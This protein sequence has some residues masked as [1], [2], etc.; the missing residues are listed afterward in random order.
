MV[1]KNL[2]LPLNLALPR[3]ENHPMLVACGIY[4]PAAI[5]QLEFL[6][7]QENFSFSDRIQNV[8]QIARA[9][10]ESPSKMDLM[11]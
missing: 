8:P 3:M 6:A 4:R 1:R 5:D 9:A 7:N 2:P 11:S 10:W